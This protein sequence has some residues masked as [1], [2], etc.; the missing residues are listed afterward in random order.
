MRDLSPSKGERTREEILNTAHRLFMQKGFHGTPMRQIAQEAG[1][2]VGGIYNHFANKDEI[3][4][5]VLFEYHPL[6]DILPALQDAQGETVEGFVRDAAQRMVEGFGNRPDFLNLMFIE[7]VEFNGQHLT[8]FFQKFFPQAITLT[9][10]FSQGND[11]LRA[12]PI[13][14][15][16][17]AFVGL[18]FSYVITEILMGKQLPLE[19]QQ[20]A[21]DHFVDIFLHGILKGA[22]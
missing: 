17:R 12:I 1:I 8:L 3:F 20:N 18:F 13:P 11:E 9:Q 15:L 7:L 21:L 2:A 6:N 5:T 4:T 22:G 14:V 16:L 10:R 19:M